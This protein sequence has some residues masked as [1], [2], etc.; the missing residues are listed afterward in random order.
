MKLKSHCGENSGIDDV[1]TYIREDKKKFAREKFEADRPHLVKKY[2][3]AGRGRRAVQVSKSK[4][5]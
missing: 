5:F 3:T 1:C 2:A 4:D